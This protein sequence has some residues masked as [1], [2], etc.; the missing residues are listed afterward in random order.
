MTSP[1][2]SPEFAVRDAA[3]AQLRAE[4][5]TFA[6][7]HGFVDRHLCGC[8]NPACR[9]AAAETMPLLGLLRAVA[10]EW[11]PEPPPVGQGLLRSRLLMFA[12][13]FGLLECP[14]DRADCP[15]LTA[16][17]QDARGLV[18]IVA[19]AWHGRAGNRVAPQG[20]GEEGE[21]AAM[22]LASWMRDTAERY[23]WN[24]GLL[25]ALALRLDPAEAGRFRVVVG[26]MAASFGRPWP[27][28]ARAMAAEAAAAWLT[29]PGEQPEIHNVLDAAL[30]IAWHADW[31]TEDAALL[32]GAAA[33][34]CMAILT[35][36]IVHPTV[37]AALYA[38]FAEAV[39][40]E[41]LQDDLERTLAVG[42][43]AA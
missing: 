35:S 33:D 37:T 34:A 16:D 38:P 31:T 25:D 4:V 30:A 13:S 26:A 11:G 7:R 20:N 19:D 36:G 14:C 41:T 23:A 12:R 24:L 21:R 17:R 3:L 28:E 15:T 42:A 39:P 18:R 1:A 22:D 10:T 32:E 43:A 8:G 40:L 5:L 6:T 29:P 2:L 27:E 9:N